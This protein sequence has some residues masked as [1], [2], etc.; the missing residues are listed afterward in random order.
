MIEVIHGVEL[1]LSESVATKNPFSTKKLTCLW[2]ST[3]S[4]GALIQL[5]K[6][7]ALSRTILK[8]KRKAP[9]AKAGT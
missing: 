6:A 8:A 4:T 5:P 1:S 2:K 3:I 7:N 9:A